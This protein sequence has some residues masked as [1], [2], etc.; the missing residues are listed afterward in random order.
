MKILLDLRK[1]QTPEALHDHLLR[2]LGFPD[3]YGKNLDALY[4]LLS[5]RDQPAV[6]SLRLPEGGPMAEYGRRVRR[7]FRDAAEANR[8][9]QVL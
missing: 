9:I 5:V 2:A 7:V 4:D 8:R 3:Y 6:F 1:D